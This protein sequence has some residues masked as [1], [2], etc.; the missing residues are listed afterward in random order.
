MI[1]GIDTTRDHATR[2]GIAR[3]SHDRVDRCG[4]LRRVAPANNCRIWRRVFDCLAKQRRIAL[5]GSAEEAIGN[6]RCSNDTITRADDQIVGRV[7]CPCSQCCYLCRSQR[8][9]VQGDVVHQ[10]EIVI[11]IFCT[12]NVDRVIGWINICDRTF[13][14]DAGFLTPIYPNHQRIAV[15]GNG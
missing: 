1:I 3:D 12:G 7:D 13:D 11:G 2:R 9:V 14:A 5:H 4:A 10:T 15:I 6:R 8:D